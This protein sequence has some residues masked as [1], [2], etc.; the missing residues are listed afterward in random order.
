MNLPPLDEENPYATPAPSSNR[1]LGCLITAWSFLGAVLGAVAGLGV[2]FCLSG[3]EDMQ[4][5][6]GIVGAILGLLVGGGVGA[7]RAI[8][9]ARFLAKK[10][11]D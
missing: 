7:L 3:Q 9:E 4:L 5:F 11:R 10:H 2:G 1:W 8:I 6:G